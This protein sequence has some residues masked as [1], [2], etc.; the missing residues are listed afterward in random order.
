MSV[1]SRSDQ[2]S[3]ELASSS[4][5]RKKEEAVRSRCK[6]SPMGLIRFRC[7]GS[8]MGSKVSLCCPRVKSMETKETSLD[9]SDRVERERNRRVGNN[10]S[11]S[12]AG[13]L[14]GSNWW[15]LL[16]QAPGKKKIQSNSVIGQRS[17]AKKKARRQKSRHNAKTQRS[18]EQ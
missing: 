17:R 5:K 6:D 7:D 18:V 12:K 15:L 10:A 14:G 11:R 9:L 8:M 13:L 16:A 3:I 2:E 4:E 1:D